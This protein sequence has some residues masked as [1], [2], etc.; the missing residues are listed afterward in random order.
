MYRKYDLA[1]ELRNARG[2]GL[3]RLD[4]DVRKWLPGDDITLE[5][6]VWVPNLEPGTYRVR[7]ALVDPSSGQPAIKLAIQ[8][9]TEDNWHDVGAIEVLPWELQP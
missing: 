5:S 6:S 7:V 2:S 9:R 1:I 3:I 4:T 8:G